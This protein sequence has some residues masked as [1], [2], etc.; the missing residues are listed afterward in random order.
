MTGQ[1]W[2]ALASA[3]LGALAASTNATA[4]PADGLHARPGV[5]GDGVEVVELDGVDTPRGALESPRAPG[6]VML[7][8]RVDGGHGGRV[9]EVP[10][11]AGRGA[12]ALDGATVAAPDAGPVVIPLS[13]GGH[14]VS[15]SVTISGYERRVACGDALRLG[16]P[17]TV[18]AGLLRFDFASPHAG[19]GSAGGGHAVVFVPPGHDATKPGALLV[20]LHPWN[21]SVWTYAAYAELL[22]EAAKRDVV[23]LMP[24]GLGNSLYTEPAEDEALRAI[25]ALAE[26]V[27]VDRA[28]VSIAGASMGGA[29]ATTIGFHAPDRFASVT[30][31]FGDSKY[32]LATYV[33]GILTSEAAAHRVNALD[34]VENARSLRVWLIHGE[35]DAVSPI[36]QS[37]MLARALQQRG[38]SIRFDRAPGV[39][40]AGAL[41]A[42]YARELV[43][44]ASEAQVQ[45]HP[46]RVTYRSVRERDRGAYGVTIERAHP[47]DAYVDVERA[48]DGAVRVH[49][50]ENVAAITLAPGALGVEAGAS[51][52]IDPAASG[53][54]VSWGAPAS[55]AR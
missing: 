36:A 52:A 25:D 5:R 7:R 10:T 17:E 19:P 55:G 9:T 20:L 13:A 31:F 29:G 45:A 26:A 3:I 34:V 27:A 39:G 21:G 11:C 42:R 53:V 22:D 4:E 12:I 33:K 46:T 41:V 54:R 15:V 28:R 8:W 14:V 1:R 2:G 30:S 43:A 38:F 50:A 18:R 35:A 37:E 44:R 32:D 48:S 24:S 49:T 16:A 23:L 47:G 40:H 6:S 51:V